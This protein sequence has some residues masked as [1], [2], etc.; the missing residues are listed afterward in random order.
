M[1][2]IFNFIFNYYNLNY[3][4]DYFL[5]RDQFK[6][7]FPNIFLHNLLK[8][9]NLF[10]Y[11]LQLNSIFSINF[12]REWLSSNNYYVLYNHLQTLIDFLYFLNWLL[13]HHKVNFKISNDNARNIPPNLFLAAQLLQYI[14]QLE[15]R[16]LFFILQKHHILFLGL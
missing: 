3:H 11:L 5:N 7:Y 13:N 16:I 14:L 8:L 9:L 6:I 4:F 10:Q 1:I 2:I 12:I 15:F